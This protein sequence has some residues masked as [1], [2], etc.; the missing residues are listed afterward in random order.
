VTGAPHP[1]PPADDADDDRAEATEPAE[2]TDLSDLSDLAAVRTRA[3]E[4]GVSVSE[5]VRD[6][7]CRA[8]GE[9]AWER[10]LAEAGEALRGPARSICDGGV[11]PTARSA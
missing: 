5:Y 7:L 10:A 4:L 6:A 8:R 1:P 2:A 11:R 3:A 9:A